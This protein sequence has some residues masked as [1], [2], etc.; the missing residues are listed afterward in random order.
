MKGAMR[1]G[2][3]DNLSPRYTGPF[4][5]VHR[6][7]EVA[8]ELD[9]PH[10]LSSVH[11]VFYVSMLKRHILDGF[12][13]IRWNLVMLDHNLSY[14]EEPISILDMQVRKLTYKDIASMK[15]QWRNHP[16]EEATW[17]M[18]SDMQVR[19]PRLFESLEVGWQMW[20]LCYYRVYAS[21]DVFSHRRMCLSEVG[22]A[23]AHF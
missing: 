15:V 18:E 12:H 8:Y 20:A 19:Y 21:A 3:K 5:I 23:P 22:S 10:G 14:E 11:P 1:F 17:E 9:L 7:G 16:V 6:V 13:V 4:E 2:K